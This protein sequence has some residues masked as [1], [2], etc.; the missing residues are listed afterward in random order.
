V[1]PPFDRGMVRWSFAASVFFLVGAYACGGDEDFPAVSS[2]WQSAPL[3]G[4]QASPCQ[5][6][7][8]M[9]CRLVWYD[10]AGRK[11]CPL[12]KQHCTAGGYWGACGD[13]PSP[14]DYGGTPSSELPPA[15]AGT[16]E[17]EE[18]PA[19]IDLH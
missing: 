12:M 4:S 10:D 11:Y 7:A 14:A 3:R 9:D 5:P 6:G 2:S 13:P 19:E 17:S 18:P 1:L 15:D 8:T 16:A